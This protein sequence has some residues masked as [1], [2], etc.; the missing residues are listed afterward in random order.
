MLPNHIGTSMR[1]I[2]TSPTPRE[3]LGHPD[4]VMT[5]G[6]DDKPRAATAAG[7]GLHRASRSPR[8]TRGAPGGRRA[9]PAL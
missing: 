5:L 1:R 7:D 4:F 6:R 2:K 9:A 8:R 3:A